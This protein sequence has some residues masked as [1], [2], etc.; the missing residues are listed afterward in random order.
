MPVR[1]LYSGRGGLSILLPSENH[2]GMKMLTVK[3][4]TVSAAAARQISILAVCPAPLPA[5]NLFIDQLAENNTL[6]QYSRRIGRQRERERQKQRQRQRLVKKMDR[7]IMTDRERDTTIA[8]GMGGQRTECG[9]E[10][11]P[12]VNQRSLN[13]ERTPALPPFPSFVKTHWQLDAITINV[14][15]RQRAHHGC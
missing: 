6:C 12:Q 11:H 9:A 4:P 13:L 5:Q 14:T 10:G 7:K 3:E 2:P 15:D 8:I 1:T